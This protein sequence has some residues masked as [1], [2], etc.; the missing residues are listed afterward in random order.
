LRREEMKSGR[1]CHCPSYSDREV[2][3]YLKSFLRKRTQ[4]TDCS[5]SKL[6]FLQG[7]WEAGWTEQ[8]LQCEVAT[9]PLTTWVT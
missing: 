8:D 4:D 6:L 2:Q 9:F 7:V 5:L 3:S 1:N